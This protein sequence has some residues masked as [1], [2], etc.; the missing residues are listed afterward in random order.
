V[1]LV[2][3][4]SPTDA[5]GYGLM[6]VGMSKRMGDESKPPVALTLRQVVWIMGY[7]ETQWKAQQGVNERREI[8]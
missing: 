8:E 5:M 4:V 2:D 6:A 7:L 1:Y 3:E